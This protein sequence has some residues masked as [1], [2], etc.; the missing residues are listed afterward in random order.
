M[1]ELSSDLWSILLPG[2]WQ[3]EQDEETIFIVD[4]DEVSIIEITPLLPEDGSSVEDLLALLDADKRK[5]VMLADLNAYY[6]EFEED[7][8]HWREW[9]CDAGGFVLTVSHGTD[10]EHKGIDDGSVDEILS[11]LLIHDEETD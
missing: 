5:A 4:D 2:E 9:L 3:A 10:I 8:M 6:L 7:E 11:T 1:N